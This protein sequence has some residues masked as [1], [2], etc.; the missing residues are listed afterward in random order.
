ML[1]SPNPEMAGSYDYSEVARSVLI[2]IAASYAAL[3]LAGR[4]TTAQG[5]VRLAWDRSRRKR[6]KLI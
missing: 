6:A 4:L 5:R 1:V 2:A 3:D